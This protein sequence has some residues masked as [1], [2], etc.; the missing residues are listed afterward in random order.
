[1]CSAPGPPSDISRPARDPLRILQHVLAV[2]GGQGQNAVHTVRRQIRQLRR[3]QQSL[4]PA[5]NPAYQSGAPELPWDRFVYTT[6][7]Q[8]ASSVSYNKDKVMTPEDM[9]SVMESAYISDRPP[10]R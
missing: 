2:K 8:M 5:E 4:Y 3:F 6:H 1:M 7:Q 9:A 10:L